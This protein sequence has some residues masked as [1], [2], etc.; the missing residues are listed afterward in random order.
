MKKAKDA[1][2]RFWTRARGIAKRGGGDGGERLETSSGN[3][4]WRLIP[5]ACALAASVAA[6]AILTRCEHGAYVVLPL[7]GASS[8]EQWSQT[9]GS[10]S[11]SAG[12][13]FVVFLIT[14]VVTVILAQM[15][16]DRQRDRAE[17]MSEMAQ[18]ARMLEVS[19]RRADLAEQVRREDAERAERREDAAERRA[20]L[21]EQARRED[22]ERAERRE[23]AA[24]RRADLAEQARREDSERAARML[25]AVERRADAAERR[26][27]LLIELIASL[28][29][30]KDNGSE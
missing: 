16:I 11:T 27:Q 21:A 13:G 12:V 2:K 19:E 28:K 9:F 24:E 1:L 30:G 8:C 23:D 7:F 20:D 25:D 17:R 15:W 10:M 29:N 22:V 4:P 26:E 5:L 14:E 18:I 3:A 6:F